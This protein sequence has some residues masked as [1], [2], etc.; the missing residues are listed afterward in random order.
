M[1]GFKKV[2][3]GLKIDID[4]RATEGRSC[5]KKESVGGFVGGWKR[6]GERRK[7]AKQKRWYDHQNTPANLAKQG[8][9]LAIFFITDKDAPMWRR[10]HAVVSSAT[11]S[12]RKRKSKTRLRG[13]SEIYYI[14]RFSPIRFN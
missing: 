2:G 13:K 1:K 12:Y 3:F 8:G 5:E 10:P 6:E 11:A 14:R 4:E 9:K 7:S